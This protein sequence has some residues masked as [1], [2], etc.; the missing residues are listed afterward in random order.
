MADSVEHQFLSQRVVDVLSDMAKSRL[1]SYT[2]A[3]RRKFDFACELQRDWSRPLVGQTLWSH[4]S[5]IDKDLRTMLL[6]TE[7]EI[8]VYVA[9]DTVHHRRL[10][11]EA[12]RDY[13]TSGLPFAPHRLRVFWIPPDFDADDDEQRRIVGDVLT[14]NVVRDVLMNVVF[15]NLTAEDVRFFVR[16]GG[17]AGLHVAVLVSIST[18][19]EP[20]RRPG[21]IGEQL[22]VS[23]GAIRERLLRLLGCGFLTQFG[24]GATR[25]QATL[26]GRVFLDLCAQL[27]RQHQTGTL[28]AEM[29]HILRLLDLRYDLEAI[30]ESARTLHL[31]GPLLTEVPKMAAGR[32]IA[33]IAAAVE[34]W[35][36]DF[37]TIEHVVPQHSVKLP[38]WWPDNPAE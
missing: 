23:P 26:K 10:L 15:G 3:E 5:G 31:A 20:Y 13:R 6:D 8:C 36:I 17:L 33:T 27:W 9:K 37:E 4:H 2:E 25:T 19:L 22:G 18:A 1:Y 28:D 24:G 32:L 11:S 38:A 16:T 14:D 29:T 30:E 12:M 7:A 21:D 35:G 34:R